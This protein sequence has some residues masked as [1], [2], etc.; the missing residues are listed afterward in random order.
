MS[1]KREKDIKIE[2]YHKKEK[3]LGVRIIVIKLGQL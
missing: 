2:M 3:L 1:K